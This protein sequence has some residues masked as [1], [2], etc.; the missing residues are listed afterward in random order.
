MS[1]ASVTNPLVFAPRAATAATATL[2]AFVVCQH[3]MSKMLAEL[4]SRPEYQRDL[5]W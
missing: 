4:A 1:P 5:G 3:G 2:G